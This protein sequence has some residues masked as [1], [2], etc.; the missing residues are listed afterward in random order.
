MAPPALKTADI[1]EITQGTKVILAAV[2]PAHGGENALFIAA[3]EGQINAA[4]GQI[5][6]HIIQQRGV[7]RSKSGSGALAMRQ[8]APLNPSTILGAGKAG[9]LADLARET[10]A[11]LVVFC[12]PVTEAQKY[13]LGNLTG[14]KVLPVSPPLK[15]GGE[16]A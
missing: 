11:E 4:G 7:L 16:T 14:A 5:V 8:A 1:K 3:V 10:G 15:G 2:V 9:E 6:G 12:N 13:V